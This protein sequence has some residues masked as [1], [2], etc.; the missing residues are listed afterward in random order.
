MQTENGYI[1]LGM[2]AAA[3]MLGVTRDE[4]RLAC[5]E[6]T[7]KEMKTVLAILKWRHDAIIRK[8]EEYAKRK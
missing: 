8:A 4:I 6:M 1:A 7:A 3:S 2:K 5:G